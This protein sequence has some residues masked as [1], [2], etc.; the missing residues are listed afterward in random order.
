MRQADIGVQREREGG[1]NN[2][3]YQVNMNH[4]VGVFKD[5]LLEVVITENRRARRRLMKELVREME[6][7]VIPLR[8][9]REVER[10]KCPRNARVH[11]NLKSNY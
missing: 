10:K 2:Y 7:R 5:R 3:E 11:H 9:N 6:R 4:A 1:E 8:L